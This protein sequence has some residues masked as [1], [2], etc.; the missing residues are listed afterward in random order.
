MDRSMSLKFLGLGRG[1]SKRGANIYSDS[2]DQVASRV[3][4]E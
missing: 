4:L 2:K 3:R 1:F